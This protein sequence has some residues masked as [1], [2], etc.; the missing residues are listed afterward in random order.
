[1]KRFTALFFIFNL[2][3]GSA[4]AANHMN[5]ADSGHNSYGSHY[6]SE[7]GYN[8]GRYNQGRYSHDRHSYNRYDRSGNRHTKSRYKLR[9]G[10]SAKHKKYSKSSKRGERVS[11]SKGVDSLKKR[12]NRLPQDKKNAAL[13][14]L[15]RHRKEMERI[16]GGDKKFPEFKYRKSGGKVNKVNNIMPTI[17]GENL[18]SVD[19][20]SNNEKTDQGTDVKTDQSSDKQEV[21]EQEQDVNSQGATK[22]VRRKYRLV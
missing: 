11:Y 1:M 7:Y 15:K 5:H 13:N 22:L 17:K 4:I 16:V 9:T 2:V 20:K 21:K 10:E 12:I 8:Q 14:E 3:S 18:K 19:K 6:E